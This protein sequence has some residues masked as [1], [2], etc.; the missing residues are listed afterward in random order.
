M[1]YVSQVLHVCMVWS[2][3]HLSQLSRL[4]PWSYRSS[5]LIS[6][7]AILTT[8]QI[9]I[10][11]KESLSKPSSVAFLP[12]SRLRQL[13]G[14]L[15]N[16]DSRRTQWISV[17]QRL[18]QC[19]Q[20]VIWHI[21][22]LP[23]PTTLKLLLLK[24]SGLDRRLED[25][26]SYCTNNYLKLLVR[27]IRY[28]LLYQSSLSI[29]PLEALRNCCHVKCLHAFEAKKWHFS[30]PI[31]VRSSKNTSIVRRECLSLSSSFWSVSGNGWWPS[32]RCGW[33]PTLSHWR[34][35]L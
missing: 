31:S 17:Y 9:N 15:D 32:F 8:L 20:R 18:D 33:P 28:W 12:L 27:A 2:S 19:R 30:Q 4:Q 21:W 25:F 1:W 29:T 13:A 22:V 7:S 35:L 14:W 11:W 24:V 23:R 16:Q 10:V 3:I 34:G 6:R 26:Y 5:V